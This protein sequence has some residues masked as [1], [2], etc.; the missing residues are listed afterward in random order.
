MSR[1]EDQKFKQ[2]AK[3]QSISRNH[4]KESNEVKKLRPPRELKHKEKGRKG[5]IHKRDT[6][7][8]AT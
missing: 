7:E 3:W 8:S 2:E 6:T 5:V 4:G 1:S